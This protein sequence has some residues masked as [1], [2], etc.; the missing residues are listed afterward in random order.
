MDGWSSELI[1][2]QGTELP[3][4]TKVAKNRRGIALRSLPESIATTT[5]SGRFMFNILVRHRPAADPPWMKLARR[6]GWRYRL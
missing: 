6:R 3:S 5:P 4:Q 1:P 2:L